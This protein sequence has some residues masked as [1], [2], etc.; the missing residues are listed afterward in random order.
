MKNIKLAVIG[1]GDITKDMLTVFKL[2]RGIQVTALC[3]I[4]E[5][6]LNK[7][8]K[9]FKKAIR[10]TDYEKMIKET[11]A[12]A[13]YI[14]LPHFLH[15]PVMKKAIEYKKHIFCEKPIT[16]KTEN[17]VEIVELAKKAEIKIAINYQY[18]YD[19]NCYRLVKAVQNED[20]GEIQFIRCSIPWSR[21]ESYFE[22]A[23]WHRS[24]EKAGGGTLITQG[25][26][27]LDI[28]LWM[29]KCDIKTAEGVCKQIKFKNVEVEDFCFAELE[30]HN[31]VHVQFLSTMASPVE[32][33]LRLEVFGEKGYGEY[34]KL[35]SSKVS[36]SGCRPP[37]YKCGKP[38]VHAVQKSSRDFRD[39]ILKGSKHLCSG[40]EAIRVLKA[41]NFI[42]KNTRGVDSEA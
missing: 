24:L 25:S 5:E 38:A 34:S 1:C 33:T 19:N 14:S 20:L 42:Y 36:F 27:L 4:N 2:T 40:E 15:Y 10:Y 6:R 12:D 9:R 26:H 8:G 3:D 17:A 39:S 13:V 28:I 22:D 21:D 11:D 18:R 16:I 32:E 31:G 37:K 23:P 7:Q 41:V 35:K 29:F 30:L